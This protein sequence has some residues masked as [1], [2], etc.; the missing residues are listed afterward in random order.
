MSSTI[1][2]K[3][4]NTRIM[5]TFIQFLMEGPKHHEEVSWVYHPHHGT[6][7]EK[8]GQI[9]D[10]IFRANDH[11][12]KI[13]SAGEDHDYEPPRGYVRID[14]PN[15]KLYYTKYN[16]KHEGVHS[17]D[18][19]DVDHHIRKNY[20]IPSH[21]K[22]VIVGRDPQGWENHHDFGHEKYIM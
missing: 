19:H 20:Q 5:Q 16:L 10:R 13:H 18:A 1:D 21:F 11:L 2:A 12:K 4:V 6:V 7:S 9:H 3:S 15:K 8:G 22:S 14:R 17:A